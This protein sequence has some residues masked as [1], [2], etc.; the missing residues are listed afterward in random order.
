MPAAPD[1]A[2]KDSAG[3]WDADGW[4]P[5]DRVYIGAS[6]GETSHR[7]AVQPEDGAPRGRQAD[8]VPAEPSAQP[9][10]IAPAPEPEIRRGDSKDFW[11]SMQVPSPQVSGLPG[12]RLAALPGGAAHI[13]GAPGGSTAGGSDDSFWDRQANPGDAGRASA[14]EGEAAGKSAEEA[15]KEGEVPR[16][17]AIKRVDSSMYWAA[18]QWDPDGRVYVGAAAGQKNHLV[19]VDLSAQEQADLVCRVWLGGLASVA[20]G[21]GDQAGPPA[22][23]SR[24]EGGMPKLNDLYEVGETLGTGSFGSVRSGTHRASGRSCAV[25]ALGK[26]GAGERYRK[27]IVDDG[28]GEG[29]L[30]MTLENPH[31]NVCRYL[32]IMEGPSHWYV[33]MENLAGPQLLEQLEEQFPVT[34]A[35]LQRVMPQVLRSLAH[36]HDPKVGLVHRDVKLSNYQFRGPGP[37]APL[38]LLDFGFA[39]RAERAWDGAHCGTLMFMA[40]EVLASSAAAPNLAAIDLWSAG[41]ILYVL[42]TG[43]APVQE[44][45][46]KLFS[47]PG[48]AAKAGEVLVRAF[49][50]EGV[51]LASEAAVE[52]LRRLLAVDPSERPTAEEAA[53]H[54]WFGQE[55]RSE[56][57]L[58]VS[59]KALNR[60]RSFSSSRTSPSARAG[61]ASPKKG[62]DV[63]AFLEMDNG[64]ERIVSGDEGP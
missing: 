43:D 63:D 52:L 11:D 8:S 20:L 6:I 34:E 1:L 48:A 5:D 2:R 12:P 60:V 49:E 28:L 15:A 26:M 14:P 55:E 21:L 31:E 54:R 23:L 10:T 32:D 9:G 58:P 62:S 17:E 24:H 38:V 47:Q 27:N 59:R 51:R 46:V 45:E 18:D 4:D 16:P 29:L 42:L 22:D 25:K 37:D 19:A 53:Q 13:P 33:V 61:G 64:L 39:C 44:D 57:Q 56:R 35:Y 3:Y 7:T 50:A 36:V 30:R 41:V 40:P